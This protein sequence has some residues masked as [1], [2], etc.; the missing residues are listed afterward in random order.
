MAR[1]T[2]LLALLPLLVS[3]GSP[4]NVDAPAELKSFKK[5]YQVD[6][7]WQK[8]V[9][10]MANASGRMHAAVHNGSIFVVDDE[11]R[12]VSL[13]ASTGKQNWTVSVE[14]P[15]STGITAGD[16]LLAFATRDG[17]VIAVSAT[18]GSKLWSAN[19]LGVVLSVPA[20]GNGKVYVQTEDGRVLA[21]SERDGSVDWT[22]ER[23]VPA[24]SLRGDSGTIYKQ[25]LLVVGFANGH[26][27]GIDS[28]N[29]RTIWDRVVAYP[30]G[31][32]DVDRIS[33]VDATPLI[34]GYRLFAASYQGKIMAMD[35]R[36]GQVLWTKP[37][38]AYLSISADSRNLYV[39]NDEGVVLAL[40]QGSG[41]NVWVQNALKRRI[42]TKPLVVNGKLILGDKEGYIQILDTSNGA[43]SGR[44]RGDG[45]K[46]LSH[47]FGDGKIYTLTDKGQLIAYT[48][49]TV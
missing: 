15:V 33:D 5:L 11:G 25:G 47:V 39:V 16:S 9:G 49:K 22:L 19:V 26:V 27:V 34:V 1:I 28:R 13:D 40:D 4:S 41:T 8:N 18:N 20:I 14:K 37:I 43:V 2:L 36:N 42:S 44:Y 21:L 24:L 45:S 29:G 10:P 35:L 17:E 6:V 3:C 31:R 7:D 38:S 12:I 48:I 46:V 30:S 23:T 32:S